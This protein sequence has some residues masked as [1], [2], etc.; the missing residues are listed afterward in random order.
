MKRAMIPYVETDL[1]NI[2]NV[3]KFGILP[4]KHLVLIVEL[5]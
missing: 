3:L 5:S 2:P 4:L 1:G